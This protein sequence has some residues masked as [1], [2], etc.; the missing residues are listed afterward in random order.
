MLVFV[1]SLRDKVGF[2]ALPKVTYKLHFMDEID[3]TVALE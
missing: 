2:L 1:I 3:S